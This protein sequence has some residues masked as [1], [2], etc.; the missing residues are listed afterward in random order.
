MNLRLASLFQDHAVLQRHALIPVWGWSQPGDSLVLQL[1]ETELKTT[2]DA[3]GYFRVN[4][5]P[6]PAGGPWTLTVSAEP[7]GQSITVSD[8]LIGEVWLCSGQ[9]NMEFTLAQCEPVMTED[10]ASADYPT[11]RNFKVV[12]HTD[13]LYIGKQ[14]FCVG[15]WQLATPENAKAFS[16]VAYTFARRL[17]R[18]LGVPVGIIDSSWGGTRIE[19]WT[20]AHGLAQIPELQQIMSRYEYEVYTGNIEERRREQELERSKCFPRD[21]GNQ[22][23]QQNWHR[24]D[25]PFHEW[26]VMRIPSLWQAHGMMFSAIFWFRKRIHLPRHWRGKTITLHVGAI[27]KQDI[28]YANGEE[29]GRMGKDVELDHWDKPRSYTIPAKL[30]AGE[31]LDLAIRVYSFMAGGGVTGADSDFYLRLSD[32]ETIPLAGD[33]HY[34]LE[35]NLGIVDHELPVIMGPGQPNSLH[36]LF[37]N[38]IAPLIPYSIQGAIWYQG[39]SNINNAGLYFEQMKQLIRDWRFHW[40]QPRFPFIITQLTGHLKE[41]DHNEA[42]VLAIVREAQLHTALQMSDVGLAVTTDIGDSHDIH[43]RNKGPIGFR[44]AQYALHHCYGRDDLVPGC[45]LPVRF[46][47]QANAVHCYFKHVADGLTTTDQQDVKTVVIAGED[48]QFYPAQTRCEKDCLVVSHPGVANPK[49]VRY[50][51][52]YNPSRANL[53]NSEG[54]PASPFRFDAE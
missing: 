54:F 1:G 21:P 22:G 28:T 5:P 46:E 3:N 2:A 16:A 8:L 11:I 43:P 25:F 29:I 41:E 9:S 38:M 50:A 20:S 37:D 15:Q 48:R 36:M 30:T 18:E 40:G 53:C 24:P 14:P 39:E 10:I 4:F 13:R 45:P 34:A 33:W 12:H 7:S 17:H 32:D 51:W 19:A 52:S 44:L 27:D 47:I 49:H 26:P 23:I 31:T 42:S 35:H 6:L